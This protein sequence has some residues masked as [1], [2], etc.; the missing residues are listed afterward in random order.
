MMSVCVNCGTETGYMCSPYGCGKCGCR[1]FSD[2]ERRLFLDDVRDPPD[3]SWAVVRSYEEF[4][5][6]IETNGVPDLISFDHDLGDG[7]PTGMDCAKFL[8]DNQLLVK[9]FQVHSA[10]TPGRKNIK[11]LLTNWTEFHRRG[12]I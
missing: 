9:G 1:I 6:Y 10:N 7:V 11:S 2:Q 12:W 5:D 8:V 4:V 3:D